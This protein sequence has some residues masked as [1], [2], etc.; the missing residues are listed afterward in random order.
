MKVKIIKAPAGL[1]KTSM[2]LKQ[3]RTATYGTAEIYVPTHKL[4]EEVIERVLQLRR[5]L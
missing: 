2:V 5:G 1:G 4:A 3:L